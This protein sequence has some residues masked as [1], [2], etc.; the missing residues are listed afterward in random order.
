[1]RNIDISKLREIVGEHNVKDNPA[2]L[3]IYGSDASV[4][5]A[6]PWVVVRPENVE[7]V[8]ALM[9]YADD[10]RITVISLVYWSGMFCL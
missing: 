9:K 8:Q 2:D 4:H 3:F 7:Q 6:M 1:M 10:E 5:R